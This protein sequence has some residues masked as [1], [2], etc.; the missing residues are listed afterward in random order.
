M[1]PCLATGPVALQPD[2]RRRAADCI[3][4]QHHPP[5]TFARRSLFLLWL[6]TAAPLARGAVNPDLAPLKRWLARQDEIRS[7]Q[8]DFTQTRSF[9]VLRDP[10]ASPGHLWFSAPE[11]F[12][13]EL[14]DPPR[15]IVLRR[16]ATAF[17]IEP[18]RK[19]AERLNPANL[20]QPG[21]PNPIPMLN[22]PLAKSFDDF[23]RQFEVLAIT[24]DGTHCHV[25]LLPRDP[26]A[27]KFLESF[28]ID[29][30]TNSGYLLS[31]E[32]RTRD[33]SSLRNDFT[34]VRFNQKVDPRV[35]D[36]DFTGF[37]I[38]DAKN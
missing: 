31:F 23:N 15:T 22:F 11:S 34:N 36:F 30:D 21:A 37:E 17:L 25:E 1:A 38:V 13:W 4:R 29:F 24:T 14:G 16:G 28:S 2:W 33:G 9:H 6:L 8:A 35:F 3:V 19:R 5:V 20:G 12:R 27:R 18:N 7:V 10:L 32:A 26:Q